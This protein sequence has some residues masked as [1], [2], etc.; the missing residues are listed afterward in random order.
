M[1]GEFSNSLFG[2]D[3]AACL[4]FRY[5]QNAKAAT[6]SRTPAIQTPTDI[7]ATA[8]CESP[9]D[10]SEMAVGVTVDVEVKLEDCDGSEAPEDFESTAAEG[11]SEAVEAR[12]V[13]DARVF[14][15]EVAESRPVGYEEKFV[16]FIPA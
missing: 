10:V 6:A 2:N 13:G 8:P 11:L 14:E 15:D 7:P 16:G 1:D 5:L 12:V 9:P 4:L 3:C